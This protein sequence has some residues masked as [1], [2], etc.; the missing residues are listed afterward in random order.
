MKG[1]ELALTAYTADVEIQ[2][3]AATPVRDKRSQRRLKLVDEM[4][5]V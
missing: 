3:I 1:L 5:R 2:G 4:A